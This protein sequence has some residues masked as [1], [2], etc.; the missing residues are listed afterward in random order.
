MYFCPLIMNP[1]SSIVGFSLTISSTSSTLQSR[2]ASALL[3]WKASLDNQSQALLSSWSGNNSCSWF[4]ITCDEDSMSLSNVS[5]TNMK[6]KG[7]FESLNF[8]SLPNILVLDLSRNS[9]QGRP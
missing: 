7:T 3:K 6:L 2:E 9:F 5:L 4:G 1:S 8:S